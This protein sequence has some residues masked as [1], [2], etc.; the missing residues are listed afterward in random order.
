[1][2][3]TAHDDRSPFRGRAVVVCLLAA[4]VTI[5]TVSAAS[6]YWKGRGT[7][8]GSAATASPQALTLT[9]ATASGQL[10]PGGQAAVSLSV[11]NPNPVSLR[12]G[13]LA[14]DTS[15]GQGGFGVDAMHSTCSPSSLSFASQTNSGNGWSVP[16]SGALSLTLPASLSMGAAAD[17]ACQGAQFTVYLKASS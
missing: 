3:A 6:A 15:Q 14:V 12:I 2:G 16:A 9:P 8:S 10:Y 7:G 13:T 11:T 1:M 17:N 5:G 4:L